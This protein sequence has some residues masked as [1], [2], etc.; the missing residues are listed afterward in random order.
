MR[1]HLLLRTRFMVGIFYDSGAMQDLS[2]L[3]QLKIMGM[4]S[5]K[6]G[7]KISQMYPFKYLLK[8]R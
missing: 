5:S 7:K 3:Y 8:N 4:I 2:Q 6:V 1:Q